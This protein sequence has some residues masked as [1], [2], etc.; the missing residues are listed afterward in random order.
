MEYKLASLQDTIKLNYIQYKVVTLQS[1]MN[2][3]TK[4]IEMYIEKI[5]NKNSKNSSSGTGNYW[6]IF[7]VIY[8]ILYFT[9]L[10]LKNW[11]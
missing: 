11:N 3:S 6:I 10:L 1:Q 7:V 2:N 9:Q 4:T 8:I 5:K